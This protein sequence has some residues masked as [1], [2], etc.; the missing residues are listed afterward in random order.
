MDN[1]APQIRMVWPEAR[2]SQPPPVML[3]PDYGL[4]LY[5][6]GDEPDFYRLMGL[7][8]WPGWDDERLRPWL[9]RVIPDGWWLVTH[10]G[11]MV[12]SAMALHNYT[13]QHPFQ[14]E[15]GW[16]AGDPAH[17]GKGIGRAVCAA[18]TG[19]LMQAGYR[20]IHLYTEQWRLPAIKTY[21]KLGFVPYLYLPEMWDRWRE[22]CDQLGWPYMPEHW[23]ANR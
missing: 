19:R 1:D 18:V 21:L 17:A 23:V 2:L 9:A 20:A 14:G 3:P 8:G 11:R 22:L 6:T 4:R 15:L 12:A 7:A 10:E 13:G 5:Q 16:V